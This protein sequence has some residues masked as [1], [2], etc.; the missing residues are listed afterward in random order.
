MVWGAARAETRSAWGNVIST[1]TMSEV[2]MGKPEVLNKVAV[3]AQYRGKALC[4]ASG[5]YQ[6]WASIRIELHVLT[7]PPF[8]NEN[9]LSFPIHFVL[10][11][12]GVAVPCVLHNLA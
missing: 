4:N 1:T 2:L 5:R 10:S 6:G 3:S 12:Y 9:C 11:C 7:L 8:V